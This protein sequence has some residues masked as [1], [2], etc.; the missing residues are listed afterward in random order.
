MP[1]QLVRLPDRGGNGGGIGNGA[2]GLIFVR[3]RH[4]GARTTEQVVEPFGVDV[5]AE[6]IGFGEDAAEK[7]DVGLNA[8]NRVFLE[9]ASQ[10]GQGFLTAVAPNAQVARPPRLLIGPRPPPR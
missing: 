2:Y 3:R 6:R 7:A 1:V 5:A 10:A 4:G 8:G 9:G